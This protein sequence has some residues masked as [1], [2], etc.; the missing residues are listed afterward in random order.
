MKT[1]PTHPTTIADKLL[2]IQGEKPALKDGWVK[3]ACVQNFNAGVE[4][5]GITMS[6]FINFI[7]SHP[8]CQE[9]IQ[10]EIDDARATGKLSDIPKI[11]ELESL[12]YLSACLNESR[13]LHPPLAHAL[14]RKVPQGGVEIDGY[15]LPAGVCLHPFQWNKTLT[16]GRPLW[17]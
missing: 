8:G 9:Q 17:E 13:R 4:T 6:T 3:D 11:R 1:R 5:I 7:A 10:R 16:S 15:F 14:A 2:Q 12:P